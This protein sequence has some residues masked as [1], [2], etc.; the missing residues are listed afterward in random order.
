MPFLKSK[1][2]AERGN[3]QVKEKLLAERATP[4]HMKGPA[5]EKSY[6]SGES[7]RRT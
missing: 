7:R 3:G 5:G 2:M 1:G 4:V 6:K